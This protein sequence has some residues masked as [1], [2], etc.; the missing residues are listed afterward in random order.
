[1]AR[2]VARVVAACAAVAVAVLHV[3][4]GLGVLVITDG[5]GVGEDLRVF[6]LT[7]GAGFA[8]AAVVVAQTRRRL[9]H[10]LVGAFI[11]PVMIMYFVMADVRH[12]HFEV[13][14][15]TIQVLQAV[16][17][18]ALVVLVVHPGRESAATAPGRRARA[19]SARRSNATRTAPGS[20]GR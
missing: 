16:L 19:V 17:L 1:M 5:G 6:G 8:V 14:G 13:W 20:A 15:V 11:P 2:G 9:V 10:A 4:I 3:L 7:A 18:V 12:P